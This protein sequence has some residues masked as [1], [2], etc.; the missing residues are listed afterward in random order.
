M[1]PVEE[2]EDINGREEY[3]DDSAMSAGSKHG[4]RYDP[5]INNNSSINSSKNRKYGM[6]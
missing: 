2:D 6:Y 5:L 3:K 1:T 4:Q